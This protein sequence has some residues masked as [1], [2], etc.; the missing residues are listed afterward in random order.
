M[1]SIGQ[2]GKKGELKRIV[3]RDSA[4]KQ[5]CLRL[6]KCSRKAAECA[7]AGFERVLEAHRL[8]QALHPDGIRWLESIDDRLHSR[9]VGLG[10]AQTRHRASETPLKAMLADFLASVDVKPST[11]IR[12]EQARSALIAH[13]TES[14]SVRT[15]SEADAE[16]WRGF[17]KS[18]GYASATISRT[19]LYAR[20]MFRW[21][22][23]RG[24][25]ESNPFAELRAGAQTNTARQVF[26]D[27]ATVAKV[28]D[29]APDAEWRLLIALSRFGG[30]RVPSEALAL[31]WQDV[32]WEHSR[33]R[34]RSAKTEHHE[35]HGERFIPIFPEVKEHL[36]AVYDAAPEGSL[37]VITRY[38]A[39]QN[40][41]PHLRRII[42]RAGVKPWVKTWHNLRASRQTEL[43]AS[44]PLHTVCA[45]IGNTKAI[46]AGHYLQTTDADW[47]RAV[48]GAPEA[49]A[50]PATQASPTTTSHHQTGQMAEAE[51]G[52]NPA[53]L[54][55]VGAGCDP[56]ASDAESREVGRAGLEPATP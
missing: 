9:V 5:R 51:T 25:V 30:L 31:T 39:G 12:M 11:K 16:A 2:E 27:R 23:K 34:V 22:V 8:G 26:I 43:A 54:V 19:V 41:N 21:G 38:R 48:G 53:D 44:Y 20:Q 47:T 35:G 29:A 6:G 40:L 55:G 33:L 7:L 14:R 4:G 24:L 1:A 28:I 32:D 52:G 36:Q 3:Y 17:L 50:I 18:E 15:I 49:A 37:H 56:V 10:L 42:Q 13:F 46:A 45:W